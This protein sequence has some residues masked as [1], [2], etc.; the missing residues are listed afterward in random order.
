MPAVT[1]KVITVAMIALNIAISKMMIRLVQF[2]TIGIP[3]VTSG[4]ERCDA[5]SSQ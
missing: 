1:S 2:G 4:H 3:D 5:P